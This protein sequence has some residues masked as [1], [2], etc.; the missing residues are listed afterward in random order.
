MKTYTSLRNLFGSLV[1]NTDSAV[2]TLADELINDAT[3]SLLAMKNWWFLERTTSISTTGGTQYVQLPANT[4]R[5]LSVAVTV[6]ANRYT[7]TSI[8]SREEWNLIN[9]NTSVQSNTPQYYFVENGLLYFYPTPSS[10]TSNGVTLT[11]RIRAF[12]LSQADY[13]T[14]NV[15][16]V[17]NGATTVTGSGTSWTSAMAGRYIKISSSNTAGGS[18]DNQWYEIASVASATSLTLARAY[19]GTTINTN[20]A[21][22]IGEVSLL[23]EPYQVIP[24]YEAIFQYYTSVQPEASRADRYRSLAQ[25][26]LARMIADSGNRDLNPV[27]DFG[28]DRPF[29]NPNLTIS[30]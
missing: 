2:L 23:P 1:N 6:G 26:H 16:A 8:G 19:L 30:L 29:I 15:S 18:G 13:T 12:D 3:R 21:Y 10:S 9:V 28:V 22:T 20:T 27:L 25:E 7:P 17:T 5:V 11:H 24:L 14:G 4:E